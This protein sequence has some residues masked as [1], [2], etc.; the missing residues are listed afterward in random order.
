MPDEQSKMPLFQHLEE[1]RTRLLICCL[2]VGVGFVVCYFFHARIFEILMKPWINAMPPGQPAKLIY[3]AP[4]EAFFV[5]M[6]VSFIAGTLLAAPVILWQVWKF[7]APGLYENEK[8]YMLPVILFSSSCFISGVLFGYFV[9]I[10]VA[11][12]FFASFSSE[13]ITPMLRTTE[14]L[15]FANKMLLC[16]GIAFQLPVFA[17]FLAKMGVLS[18]DFLKRKRK[19]AIVL[20]FIAAAVLTPSPD[21]VSQLLMAMPLLVLYEASVWIVHFFGGKPFKSVKEAGE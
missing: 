14:Y 3:T 16:F 21:V 18:A 10:P 4:Q 20:V 9:V 5:Y 12:K 17:F 11:F 7:V 15:S 1:L 8:M 19:W 13:Y 2:A 6:K